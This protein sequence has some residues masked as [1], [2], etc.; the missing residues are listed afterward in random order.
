MSLYLPLLQKALKENAIVASESMQQQWV[1]YLEALVQWNKV[2][3]LTSITEPREMVYLHIIDSLL[4]APFIQG[5]H[6][7]DVGSGAG[8]PGIPLA[9]LHP[10]QHW[11]LLDKNNKKTRFMI[12]AAAELGLK[13]ITVIHSRAEDFHPAVKFDAI[14]SRA[15]ASLSLFIETTQ[16]A[17]AP[18]GVF[19][20]MKG[21]LPED[22]LAALPRDIK[23]EKPARIT[24]KGMAIDRHVVCLRKVKN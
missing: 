21:K 13:N 22:E 9:I 4:I 3:N 2:F 16:H 10:E 1:H 11:T 19:I 17:L 15:Y 18:T 20:A 14:L 12:Q 6:C 7:L 5:K 23:A 8:L 24:M